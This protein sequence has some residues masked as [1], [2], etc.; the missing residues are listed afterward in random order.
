MNRVPKTNLDIKITTTAALF[1][2][3]GVEIFS[4]FP[5]LYD[6]IIAEGIGMLIFTTILSVILMIVRSV[7]PEFARYPYPLVFIP[8]IILLVYPLIQGVGALT[9]LIKILLQSGAVLVLFLL[10]IGHHEQLKRKW[11]FLVGTMSF[12]ASFIVFW[13]LE[14]TITANYYIWLWQS[15]AALGIIST[16]VEFPKLLKDSLR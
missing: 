1:F 11:L 9:D 8:V 2:I 16:A 13:F 5:G 6:E 10:F 15:L 7:K 3:F 4:L 12:L 14:N